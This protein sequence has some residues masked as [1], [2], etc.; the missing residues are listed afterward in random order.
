MATA[1]SCELDDIV[2]PQI[3]D[4]FKKKII[5]FLRLLKQNQE[6]ANYENYYEIIFSEIQKHQYAIII[7]NM[8]SYSP[9]LIDFIRVMIKFMSTKNNKKNKFALLFSLNTTLIY[10]KEYLD[11]IADLQLLSGEHNQICYVSE[12]VNGFIKEEQAITYLKTL[13]V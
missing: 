6:I 10:H 11:F 4:S 8:Q 7:D 1:I 2:A 3:T 13:C 12:S 9:E 5:G